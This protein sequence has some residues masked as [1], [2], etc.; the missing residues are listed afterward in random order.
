MAP[1]VERK[2]GPEACSLPSSNSET[3]PKHPTPGGGPSVLRGDIENF[4]NVASVVLY[5]DF[6]TTNNSYTAP[7][8]TK[9]G[10]VSELT[11]AAGLHNA[12]NPMGVNDAYSNYTPN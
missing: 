7:V 10:S 6:M 5:R 8:I 11:Q 3:R 2:R 9:V 1:T 12:D 4:A